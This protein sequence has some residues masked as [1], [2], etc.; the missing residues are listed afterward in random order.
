MSE[1]MKKIEKDNFLNK[2]TIND[3]YLW[4]IIKFS[5][6]YRII[7][8]KIKRKNRRSIINNL[9]NL[10]FGLTN[11][12]SR[13]D[14]IC[15]SDSSHTSKKKIN[16]MMVNRFCDPIISKIEEKKL[17][18]LDIEIPLPRHFPMKKNFNK[19][20]VSITPINI[21]AK[22]IEILLVRNIVIKNIDILKKIKIQY[23]IKQVDE[24]KLYRKFYSKFIVWSIIYKIYKPKYIFLTCYYD[25]L[26]AVVAAKYKKIK[27]IEIQHGFI[28]KTHQG[29]NYTTNIPKLYFPDF[30]LSFGEYEKNSDIKTFII[31]KENIIPIGHYYINFINSKI[32]SQK[33][34]DH[35]IIKVL[36]TLQETIQDKLIVFILES[37]KYSNKIFYDLLPRNDFDQKLTNKF[38][39]VLSQEDFYQIIQEYDV[40]VTA[41]S[42]CAIEAPSLNVPNILVNIDN[43]AKE[44]YDDILDPRTSQY[45]NNPKD[46]V[47]E[48]ENTPNQDR[49]YA[50]YNSKV[51]AQN[52]DDNLE[53]ALNKIFSS[54]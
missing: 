4:P 45:V 54:N 41:Y 24:Y 10:F 17:K 47:Q 51:I 38:V 36:V 6:F 2:I 13:Y 35:S 19:N 29:Y 37:T 49:R 15:I 40:H 32:L 44:I 52:Y 27:V 42:T 14:V 30:L 1:I 33:K 5:Y 18:T 3:F 21:I 39:K 8:G 20:I 48:I 53:S 31:D 23:K 28:G 22:I 11:W 46:F 34:Q 16:G 50:E 9:K 7:G 26:A 43:I 25:N 12:F